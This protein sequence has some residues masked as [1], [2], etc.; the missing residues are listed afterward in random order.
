VSNGAT[1]S[2]DVGAAGSPSNSV[3]QVN[4]NLLLAGTILVEDLG[5]TAASNSYPIINYTGSLTTTG[6]TNDVRSQWDVTF[7][8]N[9]PGQLKVV[10][11]NPRP[12]IQVTNGSLTVTSLTTN[13][14]ALLSG[15]AGGI[16]W[17]EVHSGK[18]AGPM[19]DFGTQAAAA[20][21]P[22]T[23]RN[24]RAGTNWVLV[25]AQ[26]HGG[27]VVSN[28]LALVLNL[29]ANTP[30]RPRPVP[31]EIW[32][33]GLSDNTGMTNY[34]QWQ[35]VQQYGDGYFFHSAGW[36]STTAGLQQSL[37]Q[38]LRPFNTRF[39]TEL[40][41]D[42]TRPST[43]SAASQVTRWGGWAAGCQD[44]G[45]YWSEFTHDYHMENMQ[46][47]CQV[48]PTWPTN[49]QTAWWTGDLTVAD[50]T[51]PY[52]NG[53]WRDVFNGY[54][55]SF[56]QVKV[57]QTSSPVWWPWDGF[58]GLDGDNLAFTVTNPANAFSFTADEIVTSFVNL[59]ATIG[60]PYFSWQTDC[61]WDY[62]GFDGSL[63]TGAENRRK[64]RT[65]E[66][67]L[68]SRQCRHT[69]ICNVSNASVA[70]QGSTNAADLY[71]ESSSLSSLYLHQQEGGRANR[72][73]FESWYPGIPGA[74]VPEWQAGTYTHLAR[75]AIQYLKGLTTNGTLEALNITPLSSQGTLAQ[76]QLVNHGDFQCL[77]TL[78]GQGGTV[79]GVSTR[80]FTANGTELTSNVL[81]PEGICFTNMLPPGG[82]TNLFAITLASAITAVTNDNACLEAFW[83]PQDPL[84]IVRDRV[85]FA[86]PLA[87]PGLWVDGDIGSPGIGGGSA[88]SGTNFTLLGSGADIW[89]AA[90]A[91]HF[92]WRT[93]IGDGTFT[94]R[95]TSQMAAD[96]W[97]K[98]GVMIRESAA[99][100]ARNVFVCVTPGNGVNFQ[101][102]AATGGASSRMGGAVL[103]VPGWLQLT[104]SGTTFTANYS[105]DG[106]A[107]TTLAIANLTGFSS[108]ALW[109]LAVTAHNNAL[110][111]AVNFDHVSPPNPP[112][113]LSPISNQTIVAGQTLIVTNRATDP[114]AAA[115]ALT[116][117]LASAPAGAA[118]DPATGLLSWRPAITQAPSTNP[119]SVVV[120]ENGPAPLSATQ[121]FAVIVWR[122][123]PPA[124]S[125]PQTT[126]GGFS[127]LVNGSSGPDYIFQCATN[128]SPPA[129]WSPLQTNL[130]ATPPFTFLDAAATNFNQRFY[131]IQLGP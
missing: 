13:L 85:F 39:W 36:D 98:A 110:A 116:F 3:L 113:T 34:S 131:R 69:L 58:P 20:V 33:G 57:G 4:G 7:D 99:A 53:I 122:P 19:T 43:N 65:Y 35:F 1:I 38:N 27:A 23:V 48:H 55:A 72:Y 11:Q 97:S 80:Y 120:T 60:H 51:Y 76:L 28:R 9:T 77:A 75:S 66:Q 91:F 47:L 18:P 129:L 121:Q 94:A 93:N 115:P 21:W 109:G 52:T 17:Y 37:A 88:I 6:L 2:V 84:G 64:I 15:T 125:L 117:R 32:W 49:D 102:R 41:G 42:M 79:P 12:L 86:G 67:Y 82:G 62:F 108:S 112:P 81:T 114:N 124:L 106:S 25:F 73:L 10:L 74:V 59:C 92:L 104:R 31:A 50:G 111:S 100:N 107:W 30:V 54:Y 103:S 68:Q 95:V 118:L 126:G 61:P 56:P 40:G 87:P 105:A 90:D 127:V 44:N 78:A 26:N 24:L 101:N 123:L 89:G 14:T 8:T 63:S 119:F 128:L 71:Y 5:G 46:P 22:F 130:A 16:A 29:P 83:N 96:A 70:N 45:I